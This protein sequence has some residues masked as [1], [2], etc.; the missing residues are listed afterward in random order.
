MQIPR[1][2]RC[3]YPDVVAQWNPCLEQASRHPPFPR[4]KSVLQSHDRDGGRADRCRQLKW[5]PPPVHGLIYV[6]SRL[7]VDPT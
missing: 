1:E 4:A 6:M 3:S 2:R 7:V 5:S